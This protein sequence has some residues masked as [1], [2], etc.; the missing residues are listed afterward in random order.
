MKQTFFF[1]VLFFFFGSA[2]LGQDDKAQMEKEKQDIQRELADLQRTYK[3]VSGQKNVTLGQLNLL[4]RKIA[5]QERYLNNINRE[6]KSLN[7]NIYLSTLEINKL[8]KQV[9]T[10]KVQY[11]RSVVYAYKN[12]SSYDFLNFIF[13]A[14][15]FND[16]VKRIAYLKSYRAYR[17]H[18]VTNIKETQQLIAKRKQ[19]QIGKVAQKKAVQQTQS[20]QVQVL[21]DQRKEKDVVVKELKTKEKDLK[22]EIAARQKR[23]RQISAQIDALIAR[24]M[25]KAKDEADRIAKA[26]A[27]NT[28][29]TSS[30]PS[31]SNP[32]TPT[33]PVVR[34]DEDYLVLNDREIALNANFE[35]NK[36]QLPWPV[37]NG[38]VSA[39]FGR[40]KDD[41]TGL[42]WDNP[43]V[44]I[45][46]PAAGHSVKAVFSG[47]VKSIF[48]IGDGM[49]VI[50]QHGKYFT[51]YSNLSSVSVSNGATVTNG[52]VIGKAGNSEDG[53]G[54][55]IDLILLNGKQKVNPESWLRR[56]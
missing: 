16:A 14:S 19:E 8:Q 23:A 29:V 53:A 47:V 39:H 21:E 17:E 56:R 1:V 6:I 30:N 41:V 32:V 33:K 45:S 2:V 52:Q 40:N 51:T 13:S 10:L 22:K 11:A 4:K 38:F 5:L 26:N 55:Q 44:T 9:D 35:K 12:R 42:T 54:G 31:G 18:Q 43:G 3:Q 27:K 48:N 25:R 34:K 49:A 50:I 15:N 7:D 24:E 36:G 37:D 20:K 46:T 28:N